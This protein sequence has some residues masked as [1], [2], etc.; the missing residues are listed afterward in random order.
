M[1]IYGGDGVG[2]FGFSGESRK[3]EEWWNGLAPDHLVTK[4]ENK[5]KKNMTLIGG[6]AA[7]LEDTCKERRTFVN[8][9][10]AVSDCF[11]PCLDP[12]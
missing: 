2:K 10:I 1:C 4:E 9:I 8:R 6:F 7:L 5:L 12:L 3:A 11:F